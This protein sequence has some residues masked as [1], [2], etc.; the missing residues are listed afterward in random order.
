[1]EPAVL[2]Q[3]PHSTRRDVKH[4]LQLEGTVGVPRPRQLRRHGPL[5]D[6][7]DLSPLGLAANVTVPGRAGHVDSST[8]LRQLHVVRKLRR[9]VI[10][11][12]FF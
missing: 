3:E 9:T 8:S 4:Q 10:V 2:R 7:R 6:Y 1:M 5:D 11:K 12:D